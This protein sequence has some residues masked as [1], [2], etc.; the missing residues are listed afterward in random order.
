M[1]HRE[2]EERRNQGILLHYDLEKPSIN[3]WGLSLIEM[4]KPARGTGRGGIWESWILFWA[5]KVWDSRETT[6]LRH[7]RGTWWCRSKTREIFCL[8]WFAVFVEI[9]NSFR[10]VNIW[11]CLDFKWWYFTWVNLGKRYVSYK[12]EFGAFSSPL[13]KIYTGHIEKLVM[14]L[15]WVLLLFQY[16]GIFSY[17]RE[18]GWNMDFGVRLP[19]FES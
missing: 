13:Q 7:Q 18:V 12:G 10:V 16:N 4:G 2:S 14:I 8:C 3:T 19:R 9:E 17:S 11:W 6:N 1:G 15:K 5:C